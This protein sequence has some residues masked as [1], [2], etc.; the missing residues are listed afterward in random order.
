MGKI[1]Q[2]GEGLTQYRVI[3]IRVEMDNIG[4]D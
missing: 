2:P 3:H 1:L 4:S